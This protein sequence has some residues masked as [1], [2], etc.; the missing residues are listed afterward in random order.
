MSGKHAPRV[1]ETIPDLDRVNAYGRSRI[2]PFVDYVAI[3][4][5]GEGHSNPTFQV[6]TATGEAHVLRA[7]PWTRSAASAHRVDREFRVISA[8]AESP[9]PVPRAIHLCEDPEPIGKTFYLM[10]FVE[11]PIFA[12]GRLPQDEAQRRQVFLALADCLGTLHAIDVRA[13]GL[14]GYG[15][16]RPGSFFERQI[17]TMTNLYRSTQTGIK[18][19][20]EDLIGYLASHTPQPVPAR[21]VHGDFRLGN[22]VM[23]T[24]LA[25]VAAVLDWE[26]STLGDPLT[27]LGYCTLMYHWDS[28]AFGS[29]IGVP[30]VPSEAE[31]VDAYCR[32]AGLAS[33]P[34][35]GFHQ[36]FS[37]FRLACI[38]QAAMHRSAIGEALQRPVPKDNEPEVLARLALRLANREARS[39]C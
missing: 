17:T 13:V 28:K 23:Q 10:E 34:A 27:D 7:M 15:G 22:V 29:V 5:I 24:N 26:L 14:S 2:D 1:F 19:E 31:F 32:R 33:V 21:L 4:P 30:G 38:T 37:L 35:L 25:G 20:M 18:P 11:G 36:A 8:L 3:R 16:R 12:N 39:T 9:L 6:V